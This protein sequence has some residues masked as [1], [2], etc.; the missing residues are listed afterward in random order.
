MKDE[1]FDFCIN[2]KC[3][4]FSKEDKNYCPLAD[5]IREK[6]GGTIIGWSCRKEWE[7]WKQEQVVNNG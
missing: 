3:G 2:K 6:N 5:R 4:K 1:F 7:Q